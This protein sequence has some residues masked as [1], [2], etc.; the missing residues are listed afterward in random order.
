MSKQQKPIEDFMVDAGCDPR[1]FHLGFVGTIREVNRHRMTMVLPCG[2]IRD[3]VFDLTHS[4]TPV[5]EQIL[6]SWLRKLRKAQ[7]ASAPVRVIGAALIGDRT[8]LFSYSR[9]S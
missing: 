3:V 7:S 2:E 9:R 6:T 4:P 5:A 8:W 1:L